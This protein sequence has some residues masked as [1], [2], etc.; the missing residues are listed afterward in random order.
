MR[1]AMSFGERHARRS[2]AMLASLVLVVAVAAF[3]SS[4][5]GW[6]LFAAMFTLACMPLFRRRHM[7]DEQ[8]RNEVMEDERDR[9]IR[10]LA[11]A[12]ARAVLVAGLLAVALVL[13]LPAGRQLLLAGDLVLPGV[14]VLLVTA[15]ALCGYAS[16]I[17][18]YRAERR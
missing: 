15:S 14:L 8:R 7:Y 16:E 1:A 12:R 6:L 17:A 2:C 11:A 18:G 5:S 3:G 13:C 10:L 9:G 4:P